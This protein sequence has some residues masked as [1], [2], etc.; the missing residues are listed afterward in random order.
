METLDCCRGREEIPEELGLIIGGLCSGW[1]SISAGGVCVRSSASAG[2][3]FG[4]N[5]FGLGKGLDGT[6]SK[7]SDDDFGD[8]E[9]VY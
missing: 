9:H 3:V 1:S 8:G 4:R 6:E 7:S 5:R 2:G